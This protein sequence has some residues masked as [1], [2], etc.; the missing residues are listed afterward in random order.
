MAHEITF[1]LNEK[2]SSYSELQTKVD[3]YCRTK[4]IQL[5]KR[6]SR[7]INSA[8]KKKN[9]SAERVSVD[10]IIRLKYYSI[11]YSCIH[12]RRKHKSESTSKR[13]SSTFKKDCA[14][15]I[16]YSMYIYVQLVYFLLEIL[17]FFQYLG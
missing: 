6:D 1:S 8:I 13:Q 15:A 3:N 4:Y 7:T 12:G 14:F 17:V 11:K 9:L 5:W 2:F 16:N 10:D